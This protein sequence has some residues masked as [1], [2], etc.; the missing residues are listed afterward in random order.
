M[1]ASGRAEAGMATNLGMSDWNTEKM[2]SKHFFVSNTRKKTMSDW[3]TEK[4]PSKHFFVSN[5]RKKTMS[6]GNTEKM[7]SKHAPS[8]HEAESPG[9]A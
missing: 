9:R 4:M 1:M 8:N 3:N 7:P 2:P 6:D 5:T